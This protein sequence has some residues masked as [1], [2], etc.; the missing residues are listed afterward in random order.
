MSKVVHEIMNHL[1]DRDWQALSKILKQINIKLDFEKVI[2]EL[3]KCKSLELMY[4]VIDGEFYI[5]IKRKGRENSKTGNNGFNLQVLV[6][7]LK[8]ILKEPL[9]KPQFL[10]I[11]KTYVN[12]KANTV[13]DM[14]IRD[15]VIE[16][17]DLSGMIFVKLSNEI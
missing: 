7:D 12:D 8:N 14:L 15:G 2:N 10:E 11:I 1:S 3:M 16:E 4:N 6:N 17:V 9:P 13:Y 5:R